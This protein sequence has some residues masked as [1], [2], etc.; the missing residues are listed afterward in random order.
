MLNTVPEDYPGRVIS[1]ESEI[2]DENSNT[3][4]SIKV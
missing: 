4:H 2:G 3:C 1:G